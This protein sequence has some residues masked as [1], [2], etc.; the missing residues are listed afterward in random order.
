M[1]LLALIL[2]LAKSFHT[3]S[4]RHLTL[5]VMPAGRLLIVHLALLFV[6]AGAGIVT[7]G[8]AMRR[9]WLPL[10][11]GVAGSTFMGLVATGWLM[12]RFAP[13]ITESNS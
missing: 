8:E 10:V 11:A 6:P 7:E 9:E 4:H 3:R 13:K 5:H 2:L 12:N 1:G